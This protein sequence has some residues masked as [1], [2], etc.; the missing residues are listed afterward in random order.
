MRLEMSKLKGEVSRR[1]ISC[2]IGVVFGYYRGLVKLTKL[3]FP[4]VAAG[5]V[6]PV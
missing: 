4:L 2:R 5:G 1:S 6:A 3:P